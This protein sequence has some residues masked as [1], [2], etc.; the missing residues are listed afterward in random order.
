MARNPFTPTFGVSPPRLAGRDDELNAF[1]EAV[2][3]GP[4]SPARGELTFAVPLLGG[5]LRRTSP[6]PGE[7]R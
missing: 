3:E 6:V 4:E 5:Y 1:R 7:N 2:T